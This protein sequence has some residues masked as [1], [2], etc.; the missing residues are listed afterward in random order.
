MK[1]HLMSAKTDKSESVTDPEFDRPLQG[2]EQRQAT[3]NRDDRRAGLAV[4]SRFLDDDLRAITSFEDA[5]SLLVES[6]TVATD[7]AEL[8]NGFT[9]L[10]KDDKRRLVGIPF[11]ILSFDFT[12]GDFGADFVSAMIMTKGGEKLIVNDGSSGICAQLRD[13]AARMPAGA[14]HRGIVC[15]HGLRASDYTY[16][17]SGVEIPAT[18]YYIDTTP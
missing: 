6:G 15:K 9:V 7:A 12:P 1:G 14:K 18:T 10:A 4:Q 3:A 2:D 11:V 8:G 16:R 5:I 17:V 13:I